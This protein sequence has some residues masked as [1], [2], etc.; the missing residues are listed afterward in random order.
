MNTA[1]SQPREATTRV[2]EFAAYKPAPSPESQR[3]P[4][5]QPLTKEK[6]GAAKATTLKAQKQPVA[7]S[8]WP[9]KYTVVQRCD[10]A[11]AR[12]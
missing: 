12:V 6:S 10:R 3:C 8:R 9:P 5:H 4:S 1:R 7:L 2:A 11:T